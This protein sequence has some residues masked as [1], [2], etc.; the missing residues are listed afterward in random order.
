[1][2]PSSYT[3]ETATLYTHLS[4]VDIY[5]DPVTYLLLSLSYYLH[6]DANAALDIPV[7]VEFSNYQTLQGIKVPLQI[8]RYV[9]GM[10]SLSITISA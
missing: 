1:M 3:A 5:Y 6:P 9:N 10:L 2:A 7:K 4:T 8:Q